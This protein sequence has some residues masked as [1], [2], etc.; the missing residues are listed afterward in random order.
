[1]VHSLNIELKSGQLASRFL[2]FGVFTLEEALAYV[3]ALPYGRNSDRANYNLV[4][5]EG[6][7]AC[8]TKHALLAALAEEISAPLSLQLGIYKMSESNTPGV[9]PVL[10]RYQISWI[11]EAHCYLKFLEERIDITQSITSLQSP[12]SDLLYE[13][14]I[15]PSMI[16]HYKVKV[17]RSYLE[18][19]S[20]EVGIPFE[21]SWA[22]R[23]ECIQA[24]ESAA[25]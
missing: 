11:P 18:E 10:D 15:Q 9:G 2:T 12:F 25:R 4:L 6:R 16:G 23:E 13:E 21:Q 14:E 3:R 22:I 19:W 8:S 20:K 5:S 24:L 17:H 1:M 7:G